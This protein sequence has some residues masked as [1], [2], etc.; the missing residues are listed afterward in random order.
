MPSSSQVAKTVPESVA[1]E[2]DYLGI[3][4][5]MAPLVA[6]EAAA[7][8]ANGDLTKPV[9]DIFLD[10]ELVWFMTPKELGGGGS[11]IRTCIEV[12]E[13]LARSDGSTGWSLMATSI[14]TL[15]AS[16]WA[17]DQVID[18][19]FGG[20]RRAIVA[21]MPGPIGK[22]T[23]LPDGKYRGGGRFGFASGSG[24]ANWFLAGML[25]MENDEILRDEKGEPKSVTFFLP[26]ERITYVPNWNVL[27]LK[28]TASNDFIVD[29]QT[30]DP[31]Y[32]TNVRTYTPLRGPERYRMGGLAFGAAGHC[33]VVLGMVR[34]A[35]E[36]I[37]VIAAGKSRLGYNGPI[38]KHPTFQQ[39]FAVQ[40]AQ[41][42]AMRARVYEVF[43]DL[44][45]AAEAGLAP[46]PPQWARMYQIVS[47]VH[48]LGP[49]IVRNCHAWAGSA[50]IRE[51]SAIARCLRD[52]ATARMHS[53]SDPIKLVTA[54]PHLIELYA[55]QARD[56]A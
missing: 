39:H 19:M 31:D 53:V 14:H 50:G 16:G 47:W 33:A 17:G 40:E 51:P 12:L 32:A 11:S 29:D 25:L 48:D 55:E 30:V 15:Y 23:R 56:R 26:R 1:G 10:T 37:A 44:E 18:A 22:A 35:L 28:G 24:Y 42:T 2:I 52:T 38:G 41:F 8:E 34:R 27:G 36:E 21:G 43:E 46:T 4:R 3:V 5:D 49:E 45:K 9:V 13:A 6:R 7:A 20:G 54:A